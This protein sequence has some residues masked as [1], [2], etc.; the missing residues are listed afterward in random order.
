[1]LLAGFHSF[2]GLLYENQGSLPGNPKGIRPKG[3]LFEIRRE[4]FGSHEAKW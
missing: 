2:D 3:P 4:I 1:M